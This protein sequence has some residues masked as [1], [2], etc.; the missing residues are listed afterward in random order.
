MYNGSTDYRYHTY[1]Y[2]NIGGILRAL[3]LINNHESI[4]DTIRIVEAT[5]YE[6]FPIFCF[7]HRF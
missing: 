1:S 3:V 4:D 7:D 5:L 6:V 2:Y